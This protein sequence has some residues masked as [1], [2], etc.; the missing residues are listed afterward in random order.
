MEARWEEIPQLVCWAK[1]RIK[2]FNEIRT[3]TMVNQAPETD[4]INN[5]T[6]YE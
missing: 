3:N 4:L 5:F 1:E 2:V 6:P